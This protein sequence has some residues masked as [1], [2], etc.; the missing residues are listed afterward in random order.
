MQTWRDT[1]ELPVPGT[2]AK[3]GS[4][5]L[6]DSA[7]HWISTHE[8]TPPEAEVPDDGFGA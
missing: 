1:I 5:P 2:G 6:L 7:D 8:C 4:E 3:A